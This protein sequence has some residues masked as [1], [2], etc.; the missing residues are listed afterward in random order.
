MHHIP[1]RRTFGVCLLDGDDFARVMGRLHQAESFG[2]NP[3]LL[4]TILLSTSVHQTLSVQTGTFKECSELEVIMGF[5]DDDHE[6]VFDQLANF[7]RMPQRL[8]VLSTRIASTQYC[9]SSCVAALDC[10]E[11]Q[12][13]TLSGGYCSSVSAELHDQMMYF[14]AC[15]EHTG[16]ITNRDNTIVQSMTQ[17][18]RISLAASV[19]NLCL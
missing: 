10:L 15:L 19:Q 2:S 16:F 11:D 13:Q 12:L 3:L 6:V 17:T 7:T 18:V 14:R 5:D 4:P 8:N 1:T 9:Y